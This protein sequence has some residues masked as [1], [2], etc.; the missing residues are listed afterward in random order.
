MSDVIQM[1]GC[2]ARH[3]LVGGFAPAPAGL[4]QDIYSQMKMGDIS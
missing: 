4:P 1:R 2:A 3:V